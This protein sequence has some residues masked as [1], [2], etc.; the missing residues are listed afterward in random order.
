MPAILM[1][2]KDF[3]N[4]SAYVD[5][6]LAGTENAPAA[7]EGELVILS[8]IGLRLVARYK[9]DHVEGNPLETTMVVALQGKLGFL[10]HAIA[11]VHLT[12]HE[13]KDEVSEDASATILEK[14]ICDI[15]VTYFFISKQLVIKPSI[16]VGSKV[17]AGKV[18][19]HI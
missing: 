18:E 1:N 14:F 5:D 4:G 17:K 3:A 2:K 12:G 8:Y 10:E 7:T 15:N 13:T 19:L 16:R 6:M 9:I 11:T